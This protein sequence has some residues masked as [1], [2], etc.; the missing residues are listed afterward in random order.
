MAHTVRD[1]D[2]GGFSC[3]DRAFI[4]LEHTSVSESL[5]PPEPPPQPAPII[6]R[7]KV[8]QVL[9]PREQVAHLLLPNQEMT[10]MPSIEWDSK[11]PVRLGTVTWKCDRVEPG[12][13]VT[14][15]RKVWS[16]ANYGYVKAWYV[17]KLD[18]S[19]KGFRVTDEYRKCVT[20][21]PSHGSKKLVT[22]AEVTSI[23]RREAEV[24]AV[25]GIAH[26]MTAYYEYPRCGI[27]LI[28]DDRFEGAQVRPLH[29]R[30]SWQIQSLP[31]QWYDELVGMGVSEA[32][33]A[34]LAGNCIAATSLIPHVQY[35]HDRISKYFEAVAVLPTKGVPWMHP[36][37]VV[38]P[39]ACRVILVPVMQRQQDMVVLTAS[40]DLP[41]IGAALQMSRDSAVTMAERW[42]RKVAPTPGH[43]LVCFIAGKFDVRG[44][45]TLV[46]A[47]P[48]SDEGVVAGSDIDMSSSS[49]QPL[50]HFQSS[51]EGVVTTVCS[52]MVAVQ[53]TDDGLGGAPHPS[54]SHGGCDGFARE[55]GPTQGV[56][57][58]TVRCEDAEAA[59]VGSSP[60]ETGT[61]ATQCAEVEASCYTSKQRAS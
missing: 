16:K 47:C 31:L 4:L 26:S 20:T 56:Q 15:K 1:A 22:E 11:W 5:G 33:I 53:R 41:F 43:H 61:E 59:G 25:D 21:I 55:A 42:M 30:E 6:T 32:H 51:V 40:G 23:L 8:R 3:R 46:V 7:S 12:A 60:G 50:S 27:M 38:Q 58:A 39:K 48:I 34:A 28:M 2:F 19:E 9:M 10:L 37:S 54:S 35:T 24:F 17:Q 18:F 44:T 29:T 36:G 13:M 57:C 49:W 45:D 52:A 14:L